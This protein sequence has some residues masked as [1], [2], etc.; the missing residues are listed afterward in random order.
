VDEQVECAS[1]DRDH[2]REGGKKLKEYSPL[3]CALTYLGAS[4]R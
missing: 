4:K 2:E 1:R 3:H